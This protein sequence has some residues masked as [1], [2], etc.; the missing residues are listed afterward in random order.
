MKNCSNSQHWIG[1]C[2]FHLT[3]SNLGMKI[4]GAEQTAPNAAKEAK[5]DLRFIL[6]FQ[7]VNEFS[8]PVIFHS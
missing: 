7:L 8:A 3:G 2:T 6:G 4:P 5:K 1:L